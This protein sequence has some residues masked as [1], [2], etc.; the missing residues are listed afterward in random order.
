ME[1]A[2]DAEGTVLDDSGNGNDLALGLVSGGLGPPVW[3]A[4]YGRSGNGGFR[5]Y[6]SNTDTDYIHMA[7]QPWSESRGTL[8]LWARTLDSGNG[9]MVPF[10]LSNGYVASKTEMAVS[11]DI[12][13]GIE[14]VSAWIMTDG[15]VLWKIVT[16]TGSFAPGI[17]HNIVVVQDGA[18]P[19]L[20]IDGEKQTVT[21]E[22]F[23]DKRAWIAAL[24]GASSP[25]S[26][27]VVGGA[28]RYY[29]PNMTLGFSGLLDEITLWDEPLSA[30][31]VD[32]I[33][34]SVEA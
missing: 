15:I 31:S 16:P 6:A 14:T 10:C 12:S 26:M 8:S 20:Y 17:W 29:F 32:S 11:I 30:A 34:H 1:T 33:Y 24:A 22:Y 21:F 9:E 18:E 25:A 28:P 3:G 7:R 19:K 23:L 5:F 4:T 13:S 2:P 27:L